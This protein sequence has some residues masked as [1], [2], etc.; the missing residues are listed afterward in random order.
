M[1]ILLCICAS[2]GLAALA[3]N[4]SGLEK[5]PRATFSQ[6]DCLD[7]N[8]DDRIDAGDAA[9]RSQVPDFDADGDRDDFDAVYLAGIDIALSPQREKSACDGRKGKAPEYLVAHGYFEP[10][11]V[12][13]DDGDAV[14]VLGIG[15]GVVNL[16]DASDAAGVR[17]TVDALLEAYDDR[18]V[19]TIAVVAGPSIVGAVEQH[20]AMEE[21]LTHAVRV[22]FDRY[23]C[24]RAVLVGHSHGGVTADVIA[25]RLEG[26]YGGRFVL[27]AD[28]DR[29]EEL[30]TGDV[31]SQ[32]AAAPVLNVYETNDP[33][34]SGDPREAPNVENWDA[35]GEV[36]SR[37]GDDEPDGPVTHTTIDN[38]VR[39]RE[40]VV[41]EVMERSET[42]Q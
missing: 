21:W 28:I 26:A 24:M 35:S 20:G 33:V 4:S 18:G 25:S 19:Q 5:A 29:V 10:A 7:L 36:A 8:G 1:K 15:G 11:D 6:L 34:L 41:A 37:N 30:Y 3:C 39:V 9:V 31:T 42:L 40:R 23:P 12:S 22:Y 2:I 16:R 13:C 27:V 14:L 38:S 32:P 17:D